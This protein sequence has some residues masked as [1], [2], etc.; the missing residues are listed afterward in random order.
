MILIG[1]ATGADATAP[2]GT[3]IAHAAAA[4]SL[5]EQ[6]VVVRRSVYRGTP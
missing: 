3:T 1:S 5:V 4:G 2:G 6:I